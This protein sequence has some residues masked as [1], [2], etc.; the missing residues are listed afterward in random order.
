[1]RHEKIKNPGRDC[2]I[3]FH[4][5]NFLKNYIRQADSTFF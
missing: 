4:E 1:L 2:L 5:I 3:K